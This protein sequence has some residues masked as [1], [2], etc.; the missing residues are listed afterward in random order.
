MPNLSVVLRV[1]TI[2]LTYGRH[3]ADTFDRRSASAGF[4]LIAR[5][6]GTSNTGVILAHIRRGILR[7][8]ALHHVLLKRAE[9]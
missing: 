2:L 4:H 6:F 7:A 5:H 1:V 3:L 9:R 8:A